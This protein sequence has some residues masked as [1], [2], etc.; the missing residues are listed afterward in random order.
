MFAA[1]TGC[2]GGRESDAYAYVQRNGGLDTEASYPYTST[3]TY[4]TM[5]Q[6]F[7]RVGITMLFIF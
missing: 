2:R 4:L 6:A 7:S 3:V 5:H 1:S